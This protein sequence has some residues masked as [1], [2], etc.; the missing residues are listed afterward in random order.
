MGCNSS[1]AEKAE[2][3]RPIAGTL[4]QEPVC[5][6]KIASWCHTI[7]PYRPIRP[8]VYD[9]WRPVSASQWKS[10]W[11]SPF[12][13]S[14]LHN[15]AAIL[16]TMTTD[17]E[18]DIILMYQT[19]FSVCAKSSPQKI[20]LSSEDE[21]SYNRRVLFLKRLF[22]C[23]A[24]CKLTYCTQENGAATHA[25]PFPL[26]SA[27]CH[28]SRILIRLEG[29]SCAEFTNFLLLGDATADEGDV[30]SPMFARWAATHAVGLHEDTCQLYEQKLTPRQ[31]LQNLD[32]GLKSKHLGLD[33]PVGGFSNTVPKDGDTMYIGPA[34]VPFRLK[35]VAGGKQVVFADEMQ[36]G[37]LYFRR[38][39]FGSEATNLSSILLGIENSAP[40]KES[41]FGGKHTAAAKNQETSP[42]G[43]RKWRDYRKGGQ[44][45]P[46]D[47]GGM[48]V[49][50]DTTAF[51]ALQRLCK[52]VELSKPYDG[53]TAGPAGQALRHEKELFKELLQS[54]DEQVGD[55]LFR[56][57]EFIR[58]EPH[59]HAGT[60][61][62]I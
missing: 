10:I 5:E 18:H 55:V 47:V 50:I 17:M 51:N 43:T 45:V 30:P 21:T 6:G 1:K 31:G 41:F 15:P 38:D 59:C 9:K 33:L 37:H 2:G 52:K 13:E 11:R 36:H 56:R 62:S 23:F 7:A 27:L 57:L 44:E 42:F 19:L 34:G 35:K 39:D 28:G 40:H 58:P 16:A 29:V 53:Y 4:L 12:V 61:A 54:S 14:Q 26:A 8:L 22:L 48:H 20:P 3:K 25:W 46:A 32:D 24:V 60:M 49:N